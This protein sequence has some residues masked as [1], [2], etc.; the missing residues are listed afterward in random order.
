MSSSCR[1][2]LQYFRHLIVVER[3]RVV[4]RDRHS[5]ARSAF[6]NSLWRSTRRS[7]PCTAT[8][9]AGI[10]LPAAM[11]VIG[12]AAAHTAGSSPNALRYVS[13]TNGSGWVAPTVTS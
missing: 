6:A 3:L 1:R 8:K 4:H 10:P 11:W 2:E 13:C 9:Y 12:D 5:P 7:G